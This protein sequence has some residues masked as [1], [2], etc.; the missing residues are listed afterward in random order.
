MVG[1]GRALTPRHAAPRDR[2]G[3]PKRKSVPASRSAHVY[4]CSPGFEPTLAEELSVE[5]SRGAEHAGLIVVPSR[6]GPSDAA[7]ARQVLPGASLIDAVGPSELADA[8]LKH[9]G[10]DEDALL[11]GRGVLHVFPPDFLRRG[12]A[13]PEPHPLSSAVDQLG[14][15]L[16]LKIEGRARKRGVEPDDRGAD[17][18]VQVLLV[19]GWR[20][21]CSASPLSDENAT[22]T[23]WP[24]LFAGGHAP[25]IGYEDAPSSAYRKLVEALGW[26][27]T[28]PGPDD[29]VLDLGAA[30]GGWSYVAL[31][32][33]AE[34]L[35]Y[36]RAD[37]ARSVAEH[38]RLKH[39]RQD[40]FTSAPLNEASWLLC[41]VIDAPE[42]SLELIERALACETL[43]AMVVTVKLKPP[44]ALGP[45]SAAKGLV[46]DAR[47]R[48]WTGRVKHLVHN[49]HEVTVMA[50]RHVERARTAV[51]SDDDR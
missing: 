32:N 1:H 37:L 27:T 20:A 8:L 51:A 9:L 28:R 19:E 14:E 30:P 21:W 41:D 7:F 36:D 44:V 5:K 25:V 33:G 45:V 29:V 12:S 3:Q 31:A 49:K 22:L 13:R 40:A 50:Q 16:S 48:G 34:V 35:A 15:L 46:R 6:D 23:S 17:R 38:P 11:S 43:K 42:R 4:L 47:R 10:P 26:M 2:P 24:A 18:L 39:V